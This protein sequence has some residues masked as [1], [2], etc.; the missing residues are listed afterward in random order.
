M[1]FGTIIPPAIQNLFR[2]LPKKLLKYNLSAD[3]LSV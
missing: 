1:L 3:L 2:Q